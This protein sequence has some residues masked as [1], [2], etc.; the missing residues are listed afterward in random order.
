VRPLLRTR[1]IPERFCG[2]GSLRR[3]A[4]SSVCSLAFTSLSNSFNFPRHTTS[5]ALTTTLLSLSQQLTDLADERISTPAAYCTS[6][7]STLPCITA[8]H[9][10][11]VIHCYITHSL[12]AAPD[13][14]GPYSDLHNERSCADDHSESIVHQW[15][16]STCCVQVFLGRPGGR[17]QS[18]AGHLPCERTCILLLLPEVKLMYVCM[19]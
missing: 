2:G 3:G 19:M 4:I 7:V 9:Y 14:R 11:S 8:I 5:S 16:S 1:A 17:F 6:S 12:T 18:G 15:S 13:Q 10:Y